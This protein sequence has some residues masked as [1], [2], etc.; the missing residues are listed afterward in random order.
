MIQTEATK[1]FNTFKEAYNGKVST[2]PESKFH[3]NKTSLK[4][5][6]GAVYFAIYQGG[7][8]N[9]MGES[10]WAKK[11]EYMQ[12]VNDMPNFVANMVETVPIRETPVVSAVGDK[13]E[14]EVLEDD[15]DCMTQVEDEDNLPESVES[16]ADCYDM[17][18]GDESNPSSPSDVEDMDE[19]KFE[20]KKCKEKTTVMMGMCESHSSKGNIDYRLYTFQDM[21]RYMKNNP[22]S[23]Y[24][25]SKGSLQKKKR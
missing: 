16:E 13:V 20:N 2:P 11:V 6:K 1:G 7:D 19:D 23:Y 18:T 25:H 22:G 14:E 15:G 12:K 9:E 5:R 17:Y 4:P 3:L 10:D 8:R 21:G 24:D